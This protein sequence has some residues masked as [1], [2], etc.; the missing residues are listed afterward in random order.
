MMVVSELPGLICKRELR[1]LFELLK[2]T[3]TNSL[4]NQGGAGRAANSDI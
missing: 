3:L 4:L 2:L 1:D